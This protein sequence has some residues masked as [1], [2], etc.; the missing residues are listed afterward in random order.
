MEKI[1]RQVFSYFVEML[2]GCCLYSHNDFYFM[3]NLR[4]RHT[5]QADVFATVSSPVLLIPA[6]MLQIEDAGD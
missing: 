3:F 2:F 5:R 4:C 6:N 1:L